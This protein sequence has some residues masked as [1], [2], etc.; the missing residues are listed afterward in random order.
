MPAEIDEQRAY[1]NRTG[2][3]P[4]GEC[5]LQV[6]M[7]YVLY[8]LKHRRNTD[9]AMLIDTLNYSPDIDMPLIGKA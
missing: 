6:K 2:N 8:L 1:I 4:E 9:A 7:C 5:G 3:L